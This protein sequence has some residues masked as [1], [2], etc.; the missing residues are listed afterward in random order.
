MASDLLDFFAGW[1]K[2]KKRWPLLLLLGIPPIFI[3]VQKYFVRSFRDTLWHPLFLL[4]SASLVALSVGLYF[5]LNFSSRVCYSKL[6]DAI[7]QRRIHAAAGVGGGR[8]ARPDGQHSG[9]HERGDRCRY[10]GRPHRRSQLLCC[11]A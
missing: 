8:M 5:A 2:Q 6:A 4:L 11:C 9:W 1:A 7:R 10:V 3:F